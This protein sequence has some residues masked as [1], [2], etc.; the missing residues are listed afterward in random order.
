MDRQT[1][2]QPQANQPLT[3]FKYCLAFE[4]ENNKRAYYPLAMILLFSL[5]S[6]ERFYRNSKALLLL[7]S[8]I[9]FLYE[10][11]SYPSADDLPFSS[12]YFVIRH[13]NLARLQGV[14][15]AI[16]FWICLKSEVLREV[17]LRSLPCYF[18]FELYSHSQFFPSPHSAPVPHLLSSL[19][20]T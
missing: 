9:V 6:S 8:N 19:N 17:K 14:H 16:F 10:E 7:F 12:K 18:S 11:T 13:S 20:Y 5:A 4:N 15:L 3:I 2:T 1:S